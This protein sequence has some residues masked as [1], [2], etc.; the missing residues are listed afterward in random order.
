MPQHCYN[1]LCA[2]QQDVDF[3]IL[4]MLPGDSIM[5]QLSWEH[6]HV[7]M[8]VWKVFPSNHTLNTCCTA[9]W[10]FRSPSHTL[11]DKGRVMHRNAISTKGIKCTI[12]KNTPSL[13]YCTYPVQG[14][15]TH[16]IW[17][18]WSSHI[19]KQ[20]FDMTI[21]KYQCI[22]YFNNILCWIRPIVFT[23]LLSLNHIL[24]GPQCIPFPLH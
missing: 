22:M 19:S 4:M 6:S 12:E 10:L 3:W 2:F 13:W 9:C 11:I 18:H 17:Y 5:W 16:Y 15:T 20:L 23:V 7:I 21:R 14:Y 8:W 1:S 24:K